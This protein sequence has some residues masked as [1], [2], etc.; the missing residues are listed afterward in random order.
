MTGSGRSGS[1]S[2]SS[3]SAGWPATPTPVNRQLGRARRDLFAVCDQIITAR[4]ARDAGEHDLLRLL[5]DARDSG[6]AMTD[7]E[8]R[9]QVLVFLLA[10]HETTS[11]AL[12]FALYLLARHPEVQQKVR[13]EV[14]EIGGLPTAAQA[15]TLAYTTMVLKETMRVFPSAPFTGRRSVAD[16]EVGGYLVPGGSDVLVAPC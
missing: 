2:R 7:A 1:C 13:A 15:A 14:D 3:R 11:T 6:T 5:L 12:T 10:G 4:R 9:D 8:V 16:D